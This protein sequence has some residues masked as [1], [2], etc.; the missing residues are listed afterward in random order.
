MYLL[1]LDIGT[2]G[3]KSAIFDELGSVQG[4]G[5]REYSIE[6]DKEGK[7]EQNP[8][9]V[10]SLAKEVIKESVQQCANPLD[11][12]AMSLSVQGDAIIPLDR[13][14]NPT[15]NAILGMD[16][17]SYPQAEFCA[18]QLGDRELFNITGMRPHPMNSLTKILFF[19]ENF[20]DEF[21]R[22][23]RITTYA[24]FI[25]N[26]LGAPPLIDYTMASRTMAFDLNK[27]CWSS[28][29]LDS[30]NIDMN[31]FSKAV[32]SGT[33]AGSIDHELARELGLPK[34]IRLICGAHDQPCC[35][36][37][38]GITKQGQGVVTTGTAEVFS[39]VSPSAMI[40]DI[41]YES[42]YPCYLGIL[43]DQY[44]TFSLNHVGGLLLKWFRD[45]FC[46]DDKAQAR[47]KDLNLFRYLDMQ[48]PEHP[49]RLLVLPHFNGSGTPWCD[50]KSR[51]AIIGMSMSTTRHDIVKAIL[52]SQTYELGINLNL[53]ETAGV[54]INS[55]KATGGGARSPQWLQIKADILNRPIQT[56]AN[57]E[58]GC[59]GAALIAGTGAGQFSNYEEA[60]NQIVKTKET[61]YPNSENYKIYK[62]KSEAYNM[63]YPA[64]KP[65]NEMLD[66]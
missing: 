31:L 28:P 15:H 18:K 10:W 59:L 29:I 40:N 1:G 13:N 48:M 5:F 12:R 36:L 17:R 32:P 58:A 25:L 26:K 47:K 57:D 21:E 49:T 61:Y 8:E 16:Y 38:A 30:L 34:N 46:G 53:L 65:I 44:F 4:Y 2:T 19:K 62:E 33:D 56:L 39:T 23:T 51:G 27:K 42:F 22:T 64:L 37:G 6:H 3:C 66:S 9:T 20:P 50:L 55:L 41:I 14:F 24:D 54:K 63:L 43:P 7:A 52:E 45:N 11:I 35:A 60:V